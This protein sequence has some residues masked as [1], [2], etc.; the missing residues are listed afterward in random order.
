MPASATICRGLG[1][2]G[3]FVVFQRETTV[4]GL[5]VY[6]LS[7]VL[8]AGLVLPAAFERSPRAI[9]RVLGAPVIAWLGLVSY[10]IYLYHQPIANALNGGVTSAGNAAV[11]FLWLA[12]AT[13]AIA[14]TAAAVSYYLLERPALRFKERRLRRPKW[15][16]EAAG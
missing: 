1:L 11:R 5:A 15:A 4:Q 3:G 6:A 10:G 12:P 13:A 14:I 9:R 8:A 2:G 16:P 7:G